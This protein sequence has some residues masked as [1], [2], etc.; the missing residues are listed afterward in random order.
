M[1]NTGRFIGAS[2]ATL[3]QK[4]SINEHKWEGNRH[5]VV[6]SEVYRAVLDEWRSGSCDPV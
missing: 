6:V 2:V 1:G 4:W 3:R 5:V